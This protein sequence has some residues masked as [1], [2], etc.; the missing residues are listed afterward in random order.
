MIG[1]KEES[2]KV[3]CFELRWSWLCKKNITSHVP[4]NNSFWQL[5]R[6]SGNIFNPIHH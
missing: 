3:L 6:E 5:S 2:I 1:E 4:S